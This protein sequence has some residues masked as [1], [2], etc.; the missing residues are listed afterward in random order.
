MAMLIDSQ[1]LRAD[2]FTL[3]KVILLAPESVARSAS[4]KYKSEVGWRHWVNLRV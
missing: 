4:G 1:K 2:G 3:R